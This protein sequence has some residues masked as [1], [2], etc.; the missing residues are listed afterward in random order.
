D[1]ASRPAIKNAVEGIEDCDIVFLAYPIWH[2]QAPKIMYTFV[3][4]YDL[5]G[6]T[7]VPFCTSG[8]SP[9]GSS[10]RNLSQSA[11][12]NWLDGRRFAAGSSR[13]TVVNWINSLGLDLN[14]K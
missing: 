1:P 5:S 8:S 10:A 11:S 9:I 14:A 2:G 3:E 12:G 6:K 4:N 13:E 7:V